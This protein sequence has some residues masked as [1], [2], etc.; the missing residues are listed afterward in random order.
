MTTLGDV[1]APAAEPIRVD[2][3]A[4]VKL[5]SVKLHGQG[6]F[7]RLIDEGK[8]PGAFKGSRARAGQ[9]VL[10]RIWGRKGAMAIIPSELDGVV[11]TAEFPVFDIDHRRV[12]SAYLMRF[13]QTPEFLAHVERASDG[14]SGQ[15]RIKSESFLRLHIPLPEMEV[16]RR[17]ARILDIADA[18]RARRS[19]VL[20]HLEELMLSVFADMFGE[21]ADGRSN[22]GRVKL[23]DLSTILTG[24]TPPRSIVSNY[25]SEIEW[26]KSD[27]LGRMFPSEA[28]ERLSE[29]GGKIARIAPAGS[30]L[31][32]CIA[33]SPKS[34]GK[35]SL[36][37][38]DVAFN[39]Q[40]NAILPSRQLVS[41]FLLVQLKAAPEL[42][43]A[44][45]TGSM[46]GLVTKSAFS[47]IEVI[48]PPLK[49]QRRFAD[50]VKS[51]DAQ[52]HRVQRALDV[53]D[54]L[55]A[56]LYSQAFRGEL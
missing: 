16:Q 28:R 53:D 46:K 8:Q 30:I 50:H 3:P 35:C 47:S 34:I 13:V 32:T 38:R 14:A 25:G 24:N 31:V 23:G 44:N 12:D 9:F 5:I 11:V 54:E 51:I 43:R 10:S 26:I 40:I 55:F 17:I 7:Q 41:E 29:Q 39:Q 18:V 19:R 49:L 4:L 56:S 36:A 2:D 52:S 45:S 27:N 21:A 33:G 48:C 15:N 22:W 1:L 6:A 20:S 42:V 37:N